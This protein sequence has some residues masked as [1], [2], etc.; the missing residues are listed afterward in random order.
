M[1]LRS[2]ALALIAAGVLLAGPTAAASAAS[3]PTD[4]DDF[5]FSS[6]DATFEV[7][8]DDDGRA[9]LRVQ[10]TRVAEFPEFD[11]SRGIV[12]GYPL[13]YRGASTEPT[14]LAVRDES[15]NDIEYETEE[16]DGILYV[17]TGGD[18]FVHGANTYVIEYEMRDIILDATETKVDEFYWDL[19]PLDSTQDVDVF[20]AEIIFDDELTSHLTGD[21]ACYEGGF[22]SHTTCELQDDGDGT[23]TVERHD[24]RAASGISVAIALEAGT[25]TQPPARLPNA[26]TDIAPYPLGGGVLL[27][28]LGGWLATKNMIRRR[29]RATGIVI[30]QYD[31]PDD[32]PPL[33]AGAIHPDARNPVSAEIIHLAVRGS[34]RIEELPDGSADKQ[35]RLRRVDAPTPDPLDA[36]A[37]QLLFGSAPSGTVLELPKNDEPFAARMQSMIASGPAAAAE[38]GLTTK[39]SSTVARVIQIIAIAVFAALAVLLLWSMFTGRESAGPVFFVTLASGI[40]LVITTVSAFRTHTVLTKEGA[41]QLEY[42]DGVREFIRVAEEDRLRMLQ[43]Y[44][45]ADRRSDGSV[46]VIHVY[47]KLLPY[48]IVFGQEREWGEVLEHSYRQANQQATWMDSS[49]V[50]FQWYAL[51]AFSSSV[52]SSSAYSAPSTA[53]SSGFGGSSGGGFSGG[54]GGGGFSGGR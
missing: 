38:R 4:V 18:E 20:H 14:I 49:N 34:L 17:L 1:H 10:E 46:D 27:L 23:F 53:S 8:I 36:N 21:T 47:E 44:S 13:S 22:G 32:M 40:L 7:G 3:Q 48:A 30:A 9:T 37:L 12:V 54:G 35:P 25:I 6:W 50:G 24:L 19:L 45:G 52:H 33:L 11:Q 29:R 43:S 15:G 16:D 39:A 41:L 51:G 26:A 31:V 42:L 28:S 2:L 5:N